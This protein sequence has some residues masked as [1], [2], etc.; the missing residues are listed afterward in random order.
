MS[1]EAGTLIKVNFQQMIRL[2]RATAPTGLPING[3][4][5]FEMTKRGD[6]EE[7]EFVRI[8]PPKDTT[9]E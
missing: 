5:E 1:I 8:V 6:I 9:N 4:F 3:T 7:W 2:P